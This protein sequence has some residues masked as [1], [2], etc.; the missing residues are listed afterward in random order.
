MFIPSG[1]PPV[2]FVGGAGQPLASV[3][4][5][6]DDAGQT[7]A[8]NGAM[9]RRINSVLVFRNM[10]AFLKDLRSSQMRI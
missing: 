8:I 7:L 9:L 1:R 2:D 5:I 6:A 3:P 4:R 10:S